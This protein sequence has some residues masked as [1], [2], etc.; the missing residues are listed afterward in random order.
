MIIIGLANP[1]DQ[2]RYRPV[3]IFSHGKR[4]P[5]SGAAQPRAS[6]PKMV[7]NRDFKQN[8]K[9]GFIGFILLLLFYY[10][11]YYYILLLLYYFIIILLYYYYYF[12]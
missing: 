5:L 3:E 8:H 12:I 10:Y 9:V 1:H 2:P 7:M 4:V 6:D 11:Y